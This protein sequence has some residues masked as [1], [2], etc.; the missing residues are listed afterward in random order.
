MLRV[1]RAGLAAALL[2]FV[3]A[4][5][6]AAEKPFKQSAL[7]E[8]AIKLEAQI[9]ID[10]GTVTKPAAALRRD[11][12]AA[13]QNNDLRTGMLVLGQLVAVAPDDASGWL[14]LGRTILQIKPRDEREKALLLDRASTAA[15]IAYQRAGDRN[16]EADSLSALGQTLADRQQWR[17]A[18]DSLRLSLELRE[19]AELRGQYEKLRADHGFRLLDF[20][21]DSDSVSPRACFQFSE[22]L[23]GRRTDFSP[24]VVVAGM[25]RPA[26]STNDKQLCVEGLKHGERYAV[27][28]RAG[29]PS[30]VK[31]TLAKS[32]EFTIFVRDR[33]PFVRFSGKAYVLPRTGQRGIP[34][35]SV[36]SKAVALSIYRIGD[37]NLIDTL[38]GYD[39]QRN[40]SRYQAERLAN[41]HGA[42]IWGGELAVEPKLNTEVTTAFPVDQAVKD[43]GPGVYAMTAE[44]KDVISNEYGQQATQWF[45]VSDLGL[46]AYTANDGIDVF[47]HSLASAEPRGSAE[48]R[49]IARNNEVLAVRQTDRNGFI[50]FEAGLARGEGGVAPAAI[51]ASEK[52]DYAFLSLK[53]PAFDLS[54]RGVTGRP[55][56]AGLDAFVYTERGVYRTGETV[57]VTGLLRDA[58]GSAAMNVPLTFVIARPDG[59]EYHRALVADQGLGGHS[60]SVPIVASASTGTWRV[61][62][63][64]DPKRPP[65]GETTFMVED[66]VPDRIEFDLTS[67]A[68]GI[69]RAAPAQL[70]VDGHFLYGAA[71]SNLELSGE[72][73]VAAAKERPGFPGYSFGL[74]DDEVTA[75]RQELDDLP[76]TDGAG[77]ATFPV[78]LNNAPASGRPLEAQITVSIAES[79]GRA[80]ERKLTLPVT[81]DAAMLGIK[82][83]FSG[84]SLGDGANA[85]FDVVMVAPDGKTL[86]KNGLR[87]DLL[88]I[89]SSYQ[90][91][92]QNGQWEYE[93]VKRTER[94]AS[95]TVDVAADKPARVSVPVK[96]GRY[97]LEITTGEANGPITSVSFDAGFYAESSTDTPDLLEVALDK[98]DY[99]P[100]DTMNVAVTARTAGRLTVNV[101]T[102]R[103][104]A[105]QS[106][107]V[108]VG[109]AR[110][111]L[112][113]GQDWGTGAYMV[114]TLRRPLDAPAQRMPGRAIG[115]Q[116]FSIE[117]AARTLALDMKLPAT[118][119]PSST[120]TVPI[121]LAGLTAGQ[122]ARVVVAA[123]DV[124]ILNLTNY[125]P[126]APDDYYLGQRRLTAEIRD[127]YGQLIDGMQGTRGQIRSGGDAAGAELSGSP[128]TQA[129]LALYS[130]I[131]TVGRDG[132][133]QVQFNIPAFAGTAR[134]MA[135]AW[136]KD[137]VGKASGDVVVRDPVVLTATLP[138]F[139]RTGDKGAVQLE[140]DNVEGTAGDYNIAV[141]SDG[142]VKLDTDKPQTLKLA[143]KQRDRISLL[144]A[145]AGAGPSTVTVKVSG[146]DHFALER[147]YPLDVRPATQILTRRSVRTLAKGETL[148]LSKDLFADFVLGTGR[149]GLSV[150]VSTSLDAATLLNALDRYPFGCSEQIASRAVAMLYVNEL[151]AQAK[152]APDGEIEQRIKDAIP[153]L[154]ARQDSN[155][156]FGLW[157]VGGE[158]PWLDAYVT[159]F[160]TRAR[161]R[162]FDVPAAAY[163]L[164]VDRLRNYVA[165][166]PEP[167]KNGGR[168]LAYALY[169]LARNGAAPI[170]DLRYIADVKLS[171]VATPIAKAQIAA[172]L[173]MVGDKA[174]A[175]SVYLAA[176]DAIS[177]QPKLDLG[178]ADFGSALRDAAALVTLASEGR[179]PQ[180]TIDDAVL[181]IDTARAL[182]SRTSTQEGAWLVLAARALARQLNAIS[183]SINGETRQ[184]AFYRSLRA[185]DLTS[186]FA[187]ANHG[188]GNVQA[189]VSVSG[190]PLTPEPAAE[191][192]FKIERS[193]HTL[194][195]ETVDPSKA[196]QNQRFVVVLKMTEPQPQFGRVIIADYLPAGFEIDNPRLVSSGET[197]TLAWIADAEEPVNTE[198]R[199]DRF[200]AAFDRNQESPPVFTVA[201]VVRAVSPGRYV[202]PQAMIEDMYRPDR[203][204]RTAT[205]AIEIT[206]K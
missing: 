153:R 70:S 29:L 96:W 147:S 127:L 155:G 206:P 123:V 81:P 204:A 65:V 97:R 157:S 3:L 75:V 49:L 94:V 137:K 126:P 103:L 77:K 46:T 185:D 18:L 43:L 108:K 193:Y 121:K 169:V 139:L 158:D 5:A 14:R 105:S 145:A 33:K 171:E 161:E 19:T 8:A 164:A 128:P 53:S 84:R 68:K 10:A 66:Y 120:L 114:A 23:P 184:G 194:D 99:K 122:E 62:A 182:S 69:S 24:F 134:V 136:S 7:D 159:D 111:S 143:A 201:Y 92:R 15:Y 197:G 28:L 73:T 125:K 124:G 71:A 74:S 21:V 199:D 115:L 101:F 52:N 2:V 175:D 187:V 119:R 22:E 88:K 26:T 179:A 200:T 190:A 156:S 67:A 205:S 116:W 138:R 170:G 63:Y 186:P 118:M 9:K 64:T 131:V 132:T 198:F 148:T 149:A 133:A 140:L 110:V 12:D 150:A 48:V 20:T 54:D 17:A 142:A 172:A 58:R 50:H 38:L 30:V 4:P 83:I 86:A 107:D 183:L 188:E 141:G 195:G 32:A 176:L 42:K 13:F 80:V 47:I 202:L 31:E 160:L 59:V 95:G 168:E 6:V 89:E 55:V 191:Q 98:P 36:N 146:P 173:A 100:G 72:I 34:V 61:V 135:V 91:Y 16:L 109:A 104:V 163:T 93:P 178:R 44:P 27:T 78:K 167:S 196:K 117:K 165:T 106:Q 154:L 152:L 82:P 174:R 177:P 39:F 35:L 85:D 189:V 180:N 203:F 41:E 90:W 45:I 40:L 1:V 57:A 51:V 151:A 181:R 76:N 130:G 60:M 162:G 129:P 192:G 144:V 37:R 79:G 11:A 25:D 87:Y 112:S 102:D 56:P 166:A 113:V